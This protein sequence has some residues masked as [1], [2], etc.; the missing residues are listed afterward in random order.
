MK[1]YIKY[2][3]AAAVNLLCVS[4]VS[5]LNPGWQLNVKAQG[6][7]S[8]TL[9]SI[10]DSDLQKL[11]ANRLSGLLGYGV[12]GEAQVGYIWDTASAFNLSSDNV[13]SGIGVSVG[14]GIAQGYA[15]QLAGS[16][17]MLGDTAEQVDVYMNIYYSPVVSF[18]V[19]GKTYFF[20]N[21]FMAGLS[22]GM[23]MIADT[24]PQYEMYSTNPNA[25]PSEVG[26]IVVDN[27]MMRTMNPFMT[28]IK[29][30]LEYN[31][32]IISNVGLIIGGYGAFNIYSPKYITMPQTVIN[33]LQGYQDQ[34]LL[35]VFDPKTTPMTSYFINSLD[36]GI[37]LGVAVEL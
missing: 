20:D 34:Q 7:G 5:A 11:S 10:S 36:F 33:M 17:V 29:L 26:T 30:E 6:G 35:P 28:T 22:V 31:V 14:I 27:D 3:F 8:L 16:Y 1:R 37:T 32:P 12:G 18:T 23:K 13:F 15:G 4:A 24:S 9:P 19:S 2:F 21:R 25:V